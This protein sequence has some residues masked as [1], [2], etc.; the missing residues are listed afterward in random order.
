[1][2]TGGDL[3]LLGIEAFVRCSETNTVVAAVVA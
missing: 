2:T 3:Y 1:M